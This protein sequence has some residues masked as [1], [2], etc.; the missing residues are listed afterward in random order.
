MSSSG[1][2]IVGEQP[3]L[4][5]TRCE[6]L[7]VERHFFDGELLDEANVIWLKTR[8]TWHRLYFEP[9]VVFWRTATEPPHAYE[10]PDIK[11]VVR[12]SDLGSRFGLEGDLVT[13]LEVNAS[14]GALEVV[15]RF[16]VGRAIAFH[17]Q[18]DRTTYRLTS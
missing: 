13:K 11:S 3:D 14:D 10:M 8:S 7:L 2:D 18:N 16:E 6:A 5:G 17:N 1:F 15:I 12:L 9:G 4:A